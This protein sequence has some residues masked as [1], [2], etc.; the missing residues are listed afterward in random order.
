MKSKKLYVFI[1][2]FMLIMITTFVLLPN[3]TKV[4]AN[5]NVTMDMLNKEIEKVE[6]SFEKKYKDIEEKIAALEG[7]VKNQEETISSQAKEI[8]NLKT[9]ISKN[10]ESISNLSN[11]TSLIERRD[12]AFYQLAYRNS[13][14][15]VLGNAAKKALEITE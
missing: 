12:D 7:T 10:S 5:A 14:M 13:G 2:V 1:G 4:S 6:K 3:F 11:R 15:S 8:E 9:I